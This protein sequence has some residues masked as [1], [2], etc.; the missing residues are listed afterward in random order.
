M[1][2]DVNDNFKAPK[3]FEKNVVNVH[4]FNNNLVSL[5]LYKCVSGM[6]CEVTSCVVVKEK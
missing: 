2:D 6:L 4:K 1:W 3:N 5:Q